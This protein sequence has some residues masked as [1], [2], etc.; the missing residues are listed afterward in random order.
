MDNNEVNL[1]SERWSEK[2]APKG[3]FPTNTFALVQRVSGLETSKADLVNGKVPAAQMPDVRTL[4]LPAYDID[5]SVADDFTK[6]TNG[7]ASVFTISNPIVKKPF[8]LFIS[9]GTLGTPLFTGYTATWNA[10]TLQSDYNPAVVM[11]LCC[12]IRESGQITLFWEN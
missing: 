5:M 12:E 1:P 7:A 4:A 9:A 2:N 10:S 3:T 8:R 11:V 6:L